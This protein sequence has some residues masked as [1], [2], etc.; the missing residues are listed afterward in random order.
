[1]RRIDEVHLRYPFYGSRK[2]SLELRAERRDANRKRIQ[3][4]MR[5]MRLEAMAPTP[6]TS[7]PHPDTLSFHICF[8]ASRFPG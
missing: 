7:E 5:L 6:K 1:M 8:G 3:R 2:L 4:L